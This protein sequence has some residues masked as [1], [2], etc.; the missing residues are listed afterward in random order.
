MVSPTKQKKQ[1]LFDDDDDDDDDASSASTNQT[2]KEDAKNLDDA[3]LGDDDK[4]TTTNNASQFQINQKYA[5]AFTSRKQKDELRRVRWERGDDNDDSSSSSEE[6]DDAALLTPQLDVSI[7]QTLRALRRR[8]PSVYDPQVRFFGKDDDDDEDDE[9]ADDNNPEVLRKSKP[10][11]YKDVVREQVLEEMEK[12]DDRASA[13]AFQD[14]DDENENAAL[15][16]DRI[17]TTR[18]AYDE[19]QKEFRRA[20]LESTRGGGDSDEND[21]DSSDNGEVLV[22]KKPRKKSNNLDDDEQLKRQL[23]QEIE[24][25]KATTRNDVDAR[26]KLVDPRGEIQDGESF[27]L[28]YFKN[29]PWIQKEDDGSSSDDDADSDNGRKLAAALKPIKDRAAAAEENGD[30]VDDEGSLQELDEADDFEAQYNFRFEQAAVAASGVEQSL[31]S[32]ARNPDT[33]LRR[34]DDRR[35]LKRR[36]RQERKAAERLAKEEQLKRLKNAK[37]QELEE[38]LSKVKAVLGHVESDQVDEAALLKLLEGD[39]DPEK[40]EELM[41]EAYNDE[42]YEKED[43]EWKSDTA[44][45]ESLRRDEDGDLLV[46]GDDEDGGLYDNQDDCDVEEETGGEEEEDEEWPEEGEEYYDDE[47]QEHQAEESELEH[48]LKAKVEDELYKLD[49]EDIVAGMPTRFKYRQVE[50]NSFGL[51]TEE[52]LFAR[53]STLKQFVSL[54]KLAPYSEQEYFAGSK[55]R[56]RFREMLKR[57]LQEE[58]DAAPVPNDGE[59]DQQPQPAG[60]EDV[61]GDTQGKKKKRRRLKKIAKNKEIN[62]AETESEEA[63]E[64]ADIGSSEQ[65]STVS[66]TKLSKSTRKRRKKPSCPEAR[67]DSGARNSSEEADKSVKTAATGEV[68]MTDTTPTLALDVAKEKDTNAKKGERKKHKKNRKPKIE[69]VTQSRLA[70]YGLI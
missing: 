16:D 65:A 11:R 56:R 18:L 21:G 45:R 22:Q 17:H 20:F 10:K 55:K 59:I 61:T 44:V 31:R 69:G 57:D 33:T 12:G 52:I 64:N 6:D 30:D 36:A 37:R 42:F 38:K 47:H 41:K 34:S 2:G 60:E 70:S 58:L 3:V 43:E 5:R 14:D 9:S 7:F 67:D 63:T 15:A 39:F 26:H 4:N 28:D 49:Y 54:K 23:D 32:Y 29:R 62:V 24:L 13:A 1:R 48:K 25:V 40:F 8:D 66:E 46:G 50:P 19:Q 53:D 27:L 51:S 68:R 35:A